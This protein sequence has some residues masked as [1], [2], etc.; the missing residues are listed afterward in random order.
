M[1]KVAGSIRD[2][3]ARVQRELAAGGRSPEIEA[4]DVVQILLAIADHVDPP[5]V[6]PVGLADARPKC[7]ENES[8]RLL[9]KDDETVH[10][11]RCRTEY[12]PGEHARPEPQAELLAAAK[13]LLEAR[14]D[15]TVTARESDR[16]RRAVDAVASD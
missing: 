4:E 10:C 9:W 15:Q 14:E 5:F 7:G 13:A 16:L 6:S 3:T 12:R 11:T 2:V 1:T 8:D